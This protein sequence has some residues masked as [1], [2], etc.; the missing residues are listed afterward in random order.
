LI[1]VLVRPAR[2]DDA[3]ALHCHC[4]PQASLDDVRDYLIWSLRQVEKGWIVRLV[5][6]VDSQAIA[7]AQLTIWGQKGEIGS[8]VVGPTFRRQ[9]LARRLLEAL[10]AEGRQ[11]GLATLEI[12][13]EEH[14]PAILSFYQQLGFRPIQGTKKGDACLATSQSDITL[15]L[16]LL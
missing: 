16:A 14:Q 11:R 4:Y 15:C 7:N 3:E 1:D 13:V 6:E 12:S 10:I 2:L 9:G 5:A 8:L